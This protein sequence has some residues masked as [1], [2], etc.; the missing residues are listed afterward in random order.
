V[1]LLGL[2]SPQKRA[3]NQKKTKKHKDQ[4]E[5]FRTSPWLEET[6]L[7]LEQLEPEQQTAEFKIPPNIDYRYFI[8]RLGQSQRAYEFGGIYNPKTRSMKVLRGFAPGEKHGFGF[9]TSTS[10]MEPRL[11]VDGKTTDD[12]FFHTH[13]WNEENVISYYKIPENSCKPSDTDTNNTM[14]LRLIEEEDGF[15]RT[16]VSIIGSRGYISITEASGIHLNETLLREFGVTDDQLLQIK[17]D[18]ALEPPVWTKNFA[19]DSQSEQLLVD[20][21]K[22]FYHDRQT[23]RTIS[24]S[25]KLKKLKEKILP[26]VSIGMSDRLIDDLARELPKYPEKHHLYNQGLT[27]S[28]AALV[29]Q[30]S[31]VKIS[32]YKVE[33]GVGL[34]EMPYDYR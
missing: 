11:N 12:I 13:P 29:Q 9:A 18:W 19:R 34:K 8:A 17:R 3:M 27:D 21:V 22:D 16:V 15:E 10:F 2:Y 32:V 33:D 24:Y 4:V 28:Q 31:G 25:T 14:A 6:I 1:N 5:G 20:L 7:K 30:M 26:Y 23:D